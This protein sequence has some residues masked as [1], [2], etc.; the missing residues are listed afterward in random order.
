MGFNTNILDEM[1][2]NIIWGIKDSPK[3]KNLRETTV[4]STKRTLYLFNC[5]ST[6]CMCWIEN[7]VN[8]RYIILIHV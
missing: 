2:G 1:I 4:L 8:I 3:G 6:L 7:I 5:K